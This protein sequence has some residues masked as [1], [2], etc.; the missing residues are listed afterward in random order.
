MAFFC[1]QNKLTKNQIWKIIDKI[2]LYKTSDDEYKIVHDRLHTKYSQ[3][4]IRQIIDFI[5]DRHIE[6]EVK[7]RH[8]ELPWIIGDDSFS[9]LLF[10]IIGRGK[11]FYHSIT[12]EKLKKMAEDEDFQECFFS[13]FC[14]YDE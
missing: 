14:T 12:S 5:L 4:Q 13:I 8:V 7:F 1:K 10:E 6:L 3:K 2:N 11:K 9:G